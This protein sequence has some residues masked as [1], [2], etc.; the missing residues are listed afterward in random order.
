MLNSELTPLKKGVY[1]LVEKRMKECPAKIFVFCV[2]NPVPERKSQN[3]SP[4]C[5]GNRA[6]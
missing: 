2:D 3:I 4:C 6:I 1:I 5:D